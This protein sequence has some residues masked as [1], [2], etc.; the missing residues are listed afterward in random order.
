MK[1]YMPSKKTLEQE[2]KWYIVDMEGEVLGRQAVR[3]ASVLR[4]KHKP[5]FTPFLDA[6]DHVI[7]INAEKVALTGRKLD[8]KM[9]YRHSGYPGGIRSNTASELLEKH[10]D[11][12]IRQ[13]VK[14]MLPKGPLGRQMLRKLKIYSGS[15]HPH[16]AQTP[17]PLDI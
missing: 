5:E 17:Q 15:E 3:I 2:R 9:Y 6:G 8:N 11:R 16:E 7:V 14:R 4:G 13:A 10:P 12:V 1:T